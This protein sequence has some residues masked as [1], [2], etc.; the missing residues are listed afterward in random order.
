MTSKETGYRFDTS[1]HQQNYKNPFGF[2]AV[3]SPFSVVGEVARMSKLCKL[4]KCA[5]YIDNGAMMKY[6]YYFKNS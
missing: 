5:I 3:S 1:A 2:W 4:D 6:L